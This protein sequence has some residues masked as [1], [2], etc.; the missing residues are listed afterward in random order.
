MK[1]YL[2]QIDRYI[3][4]NCMNIFKYASHW[5]MQSNARLFYFRCNFISLVHPKKKWNAL[6]WIHLYTIY[7]LKIFASLMGTKCFIQYKIHQFC[8][9]KNLR[10]KLIKAH[11]KYTSI[12]CFSHWFA[13]SMNHFEFITIF[14][15]AIL[16]YTIHTL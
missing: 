1:L 11:T 13:K 5:Y 6:I 12:I 16:L 9:T 10:Y 14:I 3:Y 7:H 8:F 15:L 2:I 4:A